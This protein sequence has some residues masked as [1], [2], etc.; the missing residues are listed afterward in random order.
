[1]KANILSRLLCFAMLLSALVGFSSCKEEVDA[2]NYAIKTDQTITDYLEANANNFSS[3]TAIFKA[4]KLGDE[5]DASPIYSALSARGNYTVFIVSNAAIDQY[6]TT[7]LKL[8]S[9]DELLQQDESG[10][11]VHYNDMRLIAYSC[12]IDNGN[13]SPYETPDF[14]VSGAFGTSNLNDRL[15]TCTQDGQGDYYI[16]SANSRVE[17]NNCNIECTNGMLHEVTGVVA[18]STANIGT[19]IANAHNMQLMAALMDATGWSAQ[20]IKYRDDE[21]EREEHEKN[22]FQT[23]IVSNAGNFKI[24]QHRYFGYTIFAEPDETF[25]SKLGLSVTTEDA[26][27]DKGVAYQKISEASI[28]NFLT[29]LRNKCVAMGVAGIDDADYTNP[30]NIINRFVAYHII[31]GA[32]AYDKLVRHYCEFD[33]GYGGSSGGDKKNPQRI[34]YPV[35]VWDY[36]TTI[37]NAPGLMKVTQL[38][39]HVDPDHNIYLNRISRYADGQF[40]DYRELSAPVPGVKVLPNNQV[41]EGGQLV[42]YDNNA[43][44]GFYFPIDDILFYGSD[45]R[46]KLGS[47]RIRIDLTTMLPDMLSNNQRGGEHVVYPRGYLTN[48]VQNNNDMHTLYLHEAWSGT[49]YG[50]DHQGDEMLVTGLYD[51]VLQLPPVPT[52]GT[53]EIRMG[54]SANPL[55]GMCQ[56]YFGSDPNALQPVGLPFD[57]RMTAGAGRI[58]WSDDD[59]ADEQINIENDK[60]M[61]NQGYM[62]APK[63]MQTSTQNLGEG[64]SLTFRKRRQ[65]LRRI[66]TNDVL[67]PQKTYYLR[68]KTALKKIDSQFFMDYFEFVPTNVYNGAEAEDIW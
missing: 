59:E 16:N 10:A 9:V 14:P 62:K 19:M 65:A 41:T 36:Y 47:E 15:L 34:S 44:N 48:W 6:V 68:F 55:R 4:V 64:N 56:V 67:D 29:V 66:I 18:P 17:K 24:P 2:G 40:D 35:N 31:N 38:A 7:D 5:A 25:I 58:P 26:T 45:I 27:D 49:V 22:Y 12:I 1:M 20:V 37:G 39:D 21:Y 50:A 3:L 52:R 54:V 8:G 63:Y 46:E 42:E 23:G 43:Q 61:R 33:Y 57:M 60:N 51:F 28:Q 30:N 53:Y 11:Y 32:M 13:D